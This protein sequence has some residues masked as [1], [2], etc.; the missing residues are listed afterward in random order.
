MINSTQSDVLEIRSK[1]NVGVAGY[2]RSRLG[3]GIGRQVFNVHQV[4][5]F[6]D[7]CLAVIRDSKSE[8]DLI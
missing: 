2:K 8:I 3:G 4:V 7:G 1:K 6:I 5:L